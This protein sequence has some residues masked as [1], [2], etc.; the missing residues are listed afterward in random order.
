MI[1][2]FKKPFVLAVAV[3]LTAMA[4][5]LWSQ[6]LYQGTM[7]SASAELE[8]VAGEILVKFSPAVPQETIDQVVASRGC[9]VEGVSTVAGFHIINTPSGSSEMDL[10]ATFAADPD[11]EWSSP[12]FLAYSTFHS[13]FPV[14]PNDPFLSFQTHLTLINAPAA[15]S[16]E[17]GDESVIVAVIDSG[18]AFENRPIPAYE[19]GGVVPGAANYL[20]A[21]D[22][23]LTHFV[24]GFDFIF[25]D[26]NPNDDR[27]HG[28]AVTSTI[29]QDTNNG[30]GAASIAP[31][32]TIMPIKALDFSGAG[33]LSALINSI[34]FATNNGADVINMSLGFPS[35][36]SDPIFDFFFVGLD[37]AL[38]DAHNAGVVVVAATGNDSSGLVSRPGIHPTVIATG[39]TNFD[40]LTKAGYSQ[41]SGSEAG[42]GIPPTPGFPGTVELMA[43]VGDGSDLDG[44][45]IPD[46]VVQEMIFPNNP[47]T[48]GHFLLTGTSFASPQVAAAAALLISNGKRPAKTAGG[49]QVI[50]QILRETAVDLGSAGYD[51]VFGAGQ[52]D[53]AAALMQKKITLCKVPPGNPANAHTISVS[54]NAAL[55]HLNTGSFIGPCP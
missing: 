49:V 43:P 54:I 45:G 12:N 15:W 2:L 26:P 20:I 48:F 50:R 25:N 33:T 41:F 31:G 4:S 28:T 21:P 39:A 30:A 13:S 3:V 27:F 9:S 8:Y 6:D 22:L 5:P 1:K 40:G 16:K 51:L 10:A 35:F 55:S 36:A 18:V 7:D 23:A 37:N 32:V 42:L 24:P 38:D 47:E 46:A 34:V 29:T 17:I 11:C 14:P 19:S 52:I 53:L 44:N